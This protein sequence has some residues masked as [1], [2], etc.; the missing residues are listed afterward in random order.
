MD[1]GLSIFLSS[2]FLGIILLFIFTKDRWNWKKI[3]I[4][5]VVIILVISLVSGLAIFVVYKISNTPRKMNEFMGISLK[6]TKDDI[7]FLKGEPSVI[8]EEGRIWIYEEEDFYIAYEEDKIRLIFSHSR[9][10]SILG[11]KTFL[12]SKKVIRRFG[13]PSTKSIS[14]NKT[15]HIYSYKKYNIVLLL[16][17]DRV[18]WLGI[19]N[20]EFGPINFSDL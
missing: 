18:K 19:Y 7:L 12:A 15:S 1:L 9:Y 13:P 14:K 8:E 2:Y 10:A 3:V 16:E 17:K 5:S 20:P 4:K 6:D 11:I